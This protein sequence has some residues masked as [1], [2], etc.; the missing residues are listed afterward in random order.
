MHPGTIDSDLTAAGRVYSYLRRHANKWIDAWRLTLDAKTTAI[1]TRISEVRHQLPPNERIE[2]KQEGRKWFYRW[3]K[4][5]QESAP[6][7]AICFPGMNL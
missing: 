1:S 7:E 5:K 4:V 2:V 3:A 6:F